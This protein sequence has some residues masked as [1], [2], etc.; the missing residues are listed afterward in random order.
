MGGQREEDDSF[1]EKIVLIGE[2]IGNKLR[3]CGAHSHFDFAT[4]IA[5]GG[6]G[7]S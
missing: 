6:L 3:V 4:P 7:S 2:E 5:V 1:D